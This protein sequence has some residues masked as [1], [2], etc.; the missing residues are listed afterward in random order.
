MSEHYKEWIPVHVKLLRGN[1]TLK[2]L[3]E[4]TGLSLSYL[5]DIERG[6]TSPSIETLDKIFTACGVTLTIGYQQDYVPPNYVYVKRSDAE[7]LQAVC[8]RMLG[9]GTDE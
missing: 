6:R 4:L 8:K 1:R 7:A 5:S 9:L 3:A 2:E